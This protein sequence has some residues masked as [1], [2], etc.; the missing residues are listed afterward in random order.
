MPDGDLVSGMVNHTP[1]SAMQ[2][3]RRVVAH[4]LVGWANS[5]SKLR[6]C[7]AAGGPGRRTP[8]TAGD[9][10]HRAVAPAAVAAGGRAG[11]G[12][13]RGQ[14]RGPGDA[15]ALLSS[16]AHALMC[17]AHPAICPGSDAYTMLDLDTALS[18]QPPA[19]APHPEQH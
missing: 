9:G 16:F 18:T 15:A 2:P 19:H 3:S 7:M 1:S 10:A 6:G 13:G 5:W 17:A 14:R 12:G 11:L 4:G 8:E